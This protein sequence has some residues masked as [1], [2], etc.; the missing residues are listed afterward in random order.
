MAESQTT[1]PGGLA[2][3]AASAIWELDAYW[4]G[5]RREAD[6]MLAAL[7][8]ERQEIERPRAAMLAVQRSAFDAGYD[9]AEGGEPRLEAYAAWSNGRG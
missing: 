5:A 9:A 8:R 7:Q 6:E 1:E 3:A 4:R 2:A